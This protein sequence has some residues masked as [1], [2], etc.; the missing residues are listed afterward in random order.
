MTKA[1]LDGASLALKNG[2][3]GGPRGAFTDEQWHR[4][5][6]R[7]LVEMAGKEPADIVSSAMARIKGMDR[8]R[9]N[10]YRGRCPCTSYAC[11]DCE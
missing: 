11:R 8:L 9:L 10:P 2:T 3:R 7:F 6:E 1:T 4:R 5:R